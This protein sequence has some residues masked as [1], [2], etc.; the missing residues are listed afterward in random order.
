VLVAP[1]KEF[2]S[3]DVLKVRTVVLTR[4]AFDALAAG[5]LSARAAEAAPGAAG[6]GGERTESGELGDRT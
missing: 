5:A 2:N 3:L 4:A 6:P 1:V